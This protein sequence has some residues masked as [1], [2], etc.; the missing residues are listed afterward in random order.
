M[1]R[2]QLDQH[3]I[4]KSFTTICIA[5]FI[6][7][8][9]AFVS[10][11]QA[12]EPI[13]PNPGSAGTFITE[14]ETCPQVQGSNIFAGEYDTV[15]GNGVRMWQRNSPGGANNYLYFYQSSTVTGCTDNSAAPVN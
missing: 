7:I 14:P 5:G 1:L 2:G 6:A 8:L 15:D 4:L 3:K 10:V 11:T 13:K 9:F 12:L